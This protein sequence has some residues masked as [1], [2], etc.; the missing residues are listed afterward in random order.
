MA[1]SQEMAARAKWIL[2]DAVNMQDTLRVTVA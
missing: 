2:N 1:G